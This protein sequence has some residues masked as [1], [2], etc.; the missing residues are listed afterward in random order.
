M[1]APGHV[2]ADSVASNTCGIY[3]EV[4]RPL[5][6][7]FVSFLRFLLQLLQRAFHL[8]VLS[9][10]QCKQLLA[11]KAIICI[12]TLSRAYPMVPLS[13]FFSNLFVRLCDRALVVECFRRFPTRIL[14]CDPL[15]AFLAR[16]GALYFVEHELFSPRLRSLDETAPSSFWPSGFCWRSRNPRNLQYLFLRCV[17]SISQ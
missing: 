15:F 7:R 16:C 4:A 12:A 11:L 10:R 3:S 5:P 9:N 1:S 6:P 14:S 8:S 13:R 17:A 2:Q